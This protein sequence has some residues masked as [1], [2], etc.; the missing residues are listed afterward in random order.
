MNCLYT[1]NIGLED[2]SNTSKKLIENYCKNHSID[3][4]CIEHQNINYIRDRIKFYPQAAGNYSSIYSIYDFLNSS[5]ERMIWSDIDVLI[6]T[7]NN[8]FDILPELY[9]ENGYPEGK[10]YEKDCN[11]IKLQKLKFIQ[12]LLNI[13]YS[14]TVGGGLF[15]FNKE[16]AKK[17]I[18]NVETIVDFNS[19]DSIDNYC[20]YLN[21]RQFIPRNEVFFESFVIK[22]NIT[23]KKIIKT[24]YTKQ[25]YNFNN[26]Q[27]DIAHF[28]R[29]EGKELFK[30]ILK[31]NYANL[32]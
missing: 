6:L 23:P 11:E 17:F 3:F 20:N 1:S 15:S 4:K 9:L 12:E 7:K 29:E 19:L 5:Y 32:Q 2:W 26:P 13:D 8:L 24:M 30:T 21:E 18:E 31:E 22:N 28:C 25:L 14:I 16:Y 27:C 10:I